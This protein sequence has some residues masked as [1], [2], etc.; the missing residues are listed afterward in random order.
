MRFLSK[1]SG[2]GIAILSMLILAGCATEGGPSS[3]KPAAVSPEVAQARSEYEVYRSLPSWEFGSYRNQKL[4][5]QANPSNT[6]VQISIKEQRGLLL[7]NGAVAMDFP[8]ATGRAAHPTPTGHFYIKEKISDYH[9][10]IYGR[11]FD[12]YG[13]VVLPDADKRTDPIPEGGRFVEAAMTNWMRLTDDGVGMHV[14]YVPG[15]GRSAS[16]G[17]IRLKEGTAKQV[18]DVTRVGT[19]VIIAEE[20][21]AL[22]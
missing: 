15:G 17:C 10:N 12:A 20:P 21:P 16:H 9:S 11:T 5:A 22:K 8:V 3:T 13:N 7:V 1:L 14:G 4:M 18:F 6:S 2:L 19:S